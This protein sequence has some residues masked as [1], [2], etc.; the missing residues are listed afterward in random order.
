MVVSR[1][2]QGLETNLFQLSAGE[3]NTHDL[4]TP[5][6][7]PMGKKSPPWEGERRDKTISFICL[8]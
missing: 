3:A 1:V 6:P 4:C 5:T 8:T 7:T 2:I